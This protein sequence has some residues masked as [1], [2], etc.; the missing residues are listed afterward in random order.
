[1]ADCG[2]EAGGFDGDFLHR[3]C[4]SL[5]SEVAAV[6][7]ARLDGCENGPI[8]RRQWDTDS[9]EVTDGNGSAQVNAFADLCISGLVGSIR[10]PSR[11]LLTLTPRRN[12]TSLEEI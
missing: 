6:I 7:L 1:M 2:G 4:P 10:L 8:G 11:G 3:R 9:T 12:E 5:W